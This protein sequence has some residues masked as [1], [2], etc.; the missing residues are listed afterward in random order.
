MVVSALGC[1]TVQT[2]AARAPYFV[3]ARNE[4]EGT[5]LLQGARKGK[6]TN[7]SALHGK[8]LHQSRRKTR[9]DARGWRVDDI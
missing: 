2:R 1:G 4:Y 8:D 5:Q 9:R 7:S 6:A 3:V